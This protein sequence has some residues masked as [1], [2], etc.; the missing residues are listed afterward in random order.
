M[1]E[2]KKLEELYSSGFIQDDEYNKKKGEILNNF[3]NCNTSN[4]NNLASNFIGY[5]EEFGTDLD[6]EFFSNS[7]KF[8][9]KAKLKL[10]NYVYYYMVFKNDPLSDEEEN[11]EE[12]EDFSLDPTEAS[13]PK[14]YRFDY[15]ELVSMGKVP[16][17]GEIVTFRVSSPED[18][19]ATVMKS[20]SATLSIKEIDFEVSQNYFF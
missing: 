19:E 8:E 6:D 7:I 16:P 17:Y 1:E 11:I 15:T 18:L 3:N 2:L 14:S 9:E 4:V 20:D 12:E 13:V 10:P 5:N